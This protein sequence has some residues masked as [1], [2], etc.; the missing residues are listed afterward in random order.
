MAD[1]YYETGNFELQ[2][3]AF[4]GTASAPAYSGKVKSWYG[5]MELSL[6]ASQDVTN[7]AA[8]DIADYLTMQPP[9]VMTGTI[10]LT[11]IKIADYENLFNVVKDS[12]GVYLF[13]SQQLPKEVGLS[14]KNTSKDGEGNM[15]T[16]KFI[17]YRAQIDLPPIT[18]ASVDED[19]ST[20][21]DFTMNVR[22]GYIKYTVPSGQPNAGAVKF[23]TYGIIDST[24]TNWNAIKDKFVLPYGEIP[25]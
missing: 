23:A 24:E 9:M 25:S 8:D 14:F 21:R 13:G 18:T 7:I 5:M 10:R 1:K 12:N 6:T 15:N 16:N 4:S 2:T 19:G 20:I 22:A 17:L 3:Q 11:G